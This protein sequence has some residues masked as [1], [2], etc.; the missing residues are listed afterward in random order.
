MR[1]TQLLR[2]SVTV[3]ALLAAS[4]APALAEDLEFTLNNVTNSDLV[5]FYASPAN[6][7]DWE[8]NLLDG[9]YLPAGNTVQVNIA[10][11]RTVCTYDLLSVFKDGEKVQENGVDLCSLGSYTLHQ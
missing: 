11:G 6:V 3:F 4:A 7:N 9:A 1:A 5:E 10:D 2:G 8:E